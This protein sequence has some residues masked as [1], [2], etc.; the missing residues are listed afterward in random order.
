MIPLTVAAA[1]SML[2]KSHKSVRTA[3]GAGNSRTVTAV[4]MPMVPSLPTNTP[5]RS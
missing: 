3:G 4:A 1:S 5:R 2:V